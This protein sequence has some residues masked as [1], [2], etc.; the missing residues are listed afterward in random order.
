MSGQ[1]L[2]PVLQGAIS[3]VETVS[4]FFIEN[5][6]D[7]IKTKPGFI[8][9]SLKSGLLQINIGKYAITFIFHSFTRYH[10]S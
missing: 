9:S 1:N 5:F 4:I 7:A 10:I 8:K 3:S 2:T 6:P